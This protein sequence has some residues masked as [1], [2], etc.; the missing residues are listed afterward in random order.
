MSRPQYRTAA[1]ILHYPIFNPACLSGISRELLYRLFFIQ[2]T[3]YKIENRAVQLSKK[4]C[5]DVDRHRP[6]AITIP[7][8]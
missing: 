6:A 8:S 7:H 2:M 4:T 5:G 3:N 1:I